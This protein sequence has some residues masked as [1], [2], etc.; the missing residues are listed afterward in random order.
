MYLGA[1]ML[2]LEL[3]RRKY[4]IESPRLRELEQITPL[5]ERLALRLRGDMCVSST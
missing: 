1:L 2:E 4:D 3:I 5:Q